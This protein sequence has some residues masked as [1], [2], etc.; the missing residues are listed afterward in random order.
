MKSLSKRIRI[1]QSVMFTS[2]SRT[3]RFKA[4]SSPTSFFFF[5][6]KGGSKCSMV[7]TY[8]CR[9]STTPQHPLAPSRLMWVLKSFKVFSSHLLGFRCGITGM[10]DF[11]EK[12][13][14]QGNAHTTLLHS[15]KNQINYICYSKK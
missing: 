6:A 12:I 5:W 7:I 11:K 13:A 3:V 4:R 15:P 10:I 14:F 2:C 1:D 8:Q 9:P